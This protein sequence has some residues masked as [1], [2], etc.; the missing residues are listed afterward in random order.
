M[1]KQT[2]CNL[3]YLVAAI[4]DVMFLQNLWGASQQIESIPCSRFGQALADGDIK[5]LCP[6]P[7]PDRGNSRRGRR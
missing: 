4:L 6:G 3:W 2:Q 7:G 1:Q 5:G